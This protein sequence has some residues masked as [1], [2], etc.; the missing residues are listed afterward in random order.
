M[1]EDKHPFGSIKKGIVTHIAD[2][3]EDSNG[4]KDNLADDNNAVVK[5]GIKTKIIKLER[6]IVEYLRYHK[7][8]FPCPMCVRGINKE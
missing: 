5:Q 8:I 7:T 1:N 2:G 3:R 6:E 4:T